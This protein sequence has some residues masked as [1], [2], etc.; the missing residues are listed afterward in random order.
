MATLVIT[1]IS[2]ADLL[3]QDLYTTIAAGGSA[4]VD[5]AASDIP[6]MASMI[7][8][9]ATSKATLSVT[10]T[11]DEIASGLMS[12]PQAVEA[13]DLAPVA[14]AVATGGLAI[15]RS[16]FA[17]GAG[18]SADD[19]VVYA[20]N[21]LPFK[22]RVVDCWAKVVTNVGGST[23]QARTRAL[24][25]GTLLGTMSSATAGH[26]VQTDVVATAVATPGT[27]EGLFILRS[28]SGVAGEVFLLVR[29]ES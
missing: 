21:T 10:Y 19:V 25:A 1:N 18:G 12:P 15:V 20:A 11:A 6:R 4:T 8:A 9:V 5:R 22:F 17:A 23:L 26:Q 3:I 24:G 28:D 14:A 13:R 16:S 27:L 29:P 7:D 2:G